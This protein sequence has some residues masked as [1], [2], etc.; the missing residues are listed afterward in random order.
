[1]RS[2]VNDSE[3]DNKLKPTEDRCNEV[4]WI[5]ISGFSVDFSVCKR[6]VFQ[7]LALENRQY[8]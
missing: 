6:L 7:V 5:F 4:H 2:I 1:M 8:Y 3:I